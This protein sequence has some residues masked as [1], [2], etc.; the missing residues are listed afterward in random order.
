MG[1]TAY[2]FCF[3]VIILEL[4]RESGCR[5]LSILNATELFTFKIL[6][7]KFYLNKMNYDLK[8]HVF[9]FSLP[10]FSSTTIISW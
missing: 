4:N 3:G 2:G 6:L 5:I 10:L 9:Y 1:A 8:M 7:D